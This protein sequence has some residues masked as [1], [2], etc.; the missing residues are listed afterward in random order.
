M[1]VIYFNEHLGQDETLNF[2]LRSEAGKKVLGSQLV[3]N[4][5]LRGEVVRV[6]FN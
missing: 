6:L 4:N 2:L 5:F 1:V 3:W